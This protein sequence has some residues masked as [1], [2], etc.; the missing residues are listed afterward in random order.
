[1]AVP[2]LR[3]PHPFVAL[4]L[5]RLDRPAR[6]AAS[7]SGALRLGRPVS[8]RRM[9]RL[10]LVVC[11]SVAVDRRGARVG[12]GGGFSDLEFGLLTEAGLVDDRTAVA[13][14][15]HPL[16][17]LDEPLPETDHDFRV[18]LI[19]TPDEVIRAPRSRRPPGIIWSH[20]DERKLAEVPV[21]AA[22]ARRAGQRPDAGERPRP[23][24]S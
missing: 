14:T 11:G 19:V 15:V 10:D 7:I 13:T 8:V 23:D 17:V 16:Q 12:K 18:D 2:R 1:M 6:A 4:D 24:L 20:L 21:L 3:G 5:V 9:R 22:L